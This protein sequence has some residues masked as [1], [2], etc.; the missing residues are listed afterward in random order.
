MMRSRLPE[1]SAYVLQVIQQVP[2]VKT[3]LEAVCAVFPI[4]LGF[5]QLARG[6]HVSSLMARILV[7]PCL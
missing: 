1:G 7:T 4:S 3:V 5:K 2:Q 6:L